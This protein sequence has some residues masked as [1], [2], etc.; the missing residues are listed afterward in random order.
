MPGQ[1]RPWL[2]VAD[3]LLS[4]AEDSGTDVHLCRKYLRKNGRMVFGWHIAL[5]APPRRLLQVVGG[6]QQLL[7]LAAPELEDALAGVQGGP[8]AR[9]SAPDDVAPP[10]GAPRVPEPASARADSAAAPPSGFVPSIRVV[11]NEVDPETGRVI[12][13][14]EI[15]LPH[16][17]HELNRPTPGGK[18]ATLWRGDYRRGGR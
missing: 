6:V 8:P 12:I 2:V 10:P 13:E 5:T 17:Y 4:F 18:G 9:A 15:P 11:R 3:S 7:A 1:E 14:E 16:V